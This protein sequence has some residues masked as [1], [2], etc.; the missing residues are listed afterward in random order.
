MQEP[1]EPGSV[2][3]SFQTISQCVGPSGVS[4]RLLK[5]IDF[6]S[7]FGWWMPTARFGAW[8]AAFQPE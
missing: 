7:R 8:T 5:L 4:A 3:P 1:E 6:S 2:V